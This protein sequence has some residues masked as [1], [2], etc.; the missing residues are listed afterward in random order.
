[1]VVVGLDNFYVSLH[2]DLNRR[3]TARGNNEEQF[4]YFALWLKLYNHNIIKTFVHAMEWRDGGD[5]EH[6]SIKQAKG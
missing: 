2:R 3:T 4:Y 6:P 1:M 5:E